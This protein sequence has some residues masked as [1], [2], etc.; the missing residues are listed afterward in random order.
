MGNREK[1]LGVGAAEQ[2]EGAGVKWLCFLFAG[3]KL[4][5]LYL[6]S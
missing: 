2:R 6:V 4:T 5:D 1:G 3:I